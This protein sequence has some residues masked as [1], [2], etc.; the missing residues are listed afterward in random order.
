MNTAHNGTPVVC[1]KMR[2]VSKIA[3]LYAL[4]GA[5]ASSGCTEKAEIRNSASKVPVRF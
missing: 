2:V 5:A 4:H 3:M 1:A